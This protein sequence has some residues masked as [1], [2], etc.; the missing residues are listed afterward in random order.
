MK[1]AFFNRMKFIFLA[2]LCIFCSICFFACANSVSSGGYDSDDNGKIYEIK[3]NLFV[4]GSA[5]KILN[6]SENQFR[7]VSA[8]LP[9]T[10]FYS[11]SA[12]NAENP[13][14]TYTAQVSGSVFSIKLSKGTWN[15]TAEGFSDA[16][17][18]LSVLK[19]RTFVS[20]EDENSVKAGISVKMSPQTGG[21]GNISLSLEVENGSGIKSVLA[22]L[23]KNGESSSVY[24]ESLNFS[25]N[26]AKIEQ[27]DVSSG[28]YVLSLKF[29]SELD[30]AGELF[31]AAQEIV[32]VF[33][34]LTTDTW[35][36][37]SVYFSGGKFV[38]SKSAVESFKMNTF[39]VQGES[40]TTYSPVASADDS[41][42]GTYFAP[43]KTVQ[44][45]VDKINALNSGTTE[46]TIFV[47][48]TVT[49]DSSGDYSANNSSF[50]NISPASTLN[51]TI[52]SLSS[53]KSVVDAGRNG[54][55]AD[56]SGWRVFYIGENA[57]VAFENITVTGGSLDS[58]G[59]GIYCDGN[60]I[61]RN[62]TVNSNINYNDGNLTLE[63]AISVENSIKIS[64]GLQIG[65]KN[66]A[67][68]K[69]LKLSGK[70]DTE[71]WNVGT[72]IIHSA[73]GIALSDLICSKF[74]VQNKNADKKVLCIV[75]SSMDAVKGV[76]AIAGSA[77]I[78]SFNQPE[79]T[80]TL[81]PA[82]FSSA[83]ADN[84]ISLAVT[85]SDGNAVTPD[86]VEFALYQ[87]KNKVAVLQGGLLPSWIPE[88]NY[89][90]I[91]TAKIGG[92][93]YDAEMNIIISVAI[94]SLASAPS[95]S[96]FPKITASSSQELVTLRS[97]VN[98]G[99]DLEGIT[100]TLLDDIDLA[101]CADDWQPIGFVK[102][103]DDDSNNM[104]FKGT[105]NGN[106]KTILYKITKNEDS[107][108][109]LFGLFFDNYGTIENLVVNQ[110]YS[111]DLSDR[112]MSRGGMICAYNYG[113][114]RN[115]IVKADIAI[116][117]KSD[118]AGIC[119]VNTESGKVVNCFV[120]G[121]MENQLY[122]NWN[123]SY[124]K[125][126]GICAINYG[127]VENAVSSA[128]I[129]TKSVIE[130]TK[131]LNHISGAIAART[132]GYLKNCY[133]LKDNID[134]G[135]TAVNQIAYINKETG[136]YTDEICIPDPSKI[137]GCGYFETNSPSASVAPGTT[138]ECKSA[139][140]LS[141]S[142]TLLEI[143]NAYVSASSDSGLKQWKADS[144]GNL[145]LDFYNP[146][147]NLQF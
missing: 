46:Y 93:S 24:S 83:K 36:G 97:W 15:I 3:G 30:C 63:G 147:F 70:T 67:S 5:P 141:Y 68:L 7:G 17:K 94:S 50:V 4:E 21:K 33:N 113:N 35:H 20:V 142:G 133:W 62:C 51:L 6:K 114:I 103:E 44:A 137:T 2:S 47:D 144:S 37:N 54:Q 87:N 116:G 61:L 56:S 125:T 13:V 64:A 127:T 98:S 107:G 117:T 71:E 130:K 39:F 9:G 120:T 92:Y 95:A 86:T 45:A 110:T 60:L 48:G 118:T 22:E 111:G 10:I 12:K 80:L 145:T 90:V 108:T 32:N 129:K 96:D 126:G 134:R 69:T 138:S 105:F 119:K 99:S 112:G 140:T 40:E 28:V 57:N 101:D 131:Q 65:I 88:G 85:D 139:Q 59:G 8:E 132:D 16:E 42:A 115:C 109:Q 123:E 31:Y 75:P 81:S 52:K 1:N 29:Y 41:N 43:L 73:E 143:Q 18:T 58:S 74:A 11:V 79:Y 26:T 25:S 34:N 89:T 53:E 14:K 49:A 124:Q 135:G 136:A 72:E 23:Y 19:G 84:K 128:H 104:P 146:F 121:N 106:G 55:N 38:L 91:A 100:I 82:L 76:L 27:S 102:N 122:V 66:L 77:V 78:P